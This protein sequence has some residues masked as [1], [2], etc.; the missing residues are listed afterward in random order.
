MDEQ[1]APYV[2]RDVY[3]SVVIPETLG[4]VELRP[5]LP[6]EGTAEAILAH[7]RSQF[8]V[9]DNVASF[10]YHPFLGTEQLED[11]VNRMRSMGYR[12]VAPCEL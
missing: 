5:S 11:I 6:D 12:F 8:V 1:F 3:G 7:A 10:F 9:R 4:M 2:I